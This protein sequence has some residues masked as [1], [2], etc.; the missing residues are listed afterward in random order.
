[1]TKEEIIEKLRT[2]KGYQKKGAQFLA[3][4]W[5]VSLDLIK[6]CKKLVG[7][8]EWIQE[9]INNDN[10]NELNTDYNII[11]RGHP[12]FHNST[13]SLEESFKKSSILILA[14]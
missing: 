2:R 10:E 11:V 12:A 4:K 13:E 1:M 14:T 9:R 6:E 7:S 8:E 3:D 5:E